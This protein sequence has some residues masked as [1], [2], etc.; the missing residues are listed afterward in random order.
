MGQVCTL[1]HWATLEGQPLF[2]P[3]T[4][5]ALLGPDSQLSEARKVQVVQWTR[6][7]WAQ[8]C[9]KRGPGHPTQGVRAGR[10]QG[11]QRRGPCS[12]LKGVRSGW[13]ESHT[14]LFPVAW[15]SAEREVGRLSC[16]WVYRRLACVCLEQSLY[17]T[18]TSETDFI[19]R[20]EHEWFLW[21]ACFQSPCLTGVCVQ[22]SKYFYGDSVHN[23]MAI[24]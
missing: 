8:P 5:I 22:L 23:T 6:D 10:K 1:Y 19:N 14:Q 4:V 18:A 11:P 2:V 17:L 24:I 20:C 3:A 15:L 9:C 21:L 12:S 16:P 7:F 13:A